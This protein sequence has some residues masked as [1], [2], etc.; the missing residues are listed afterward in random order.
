MNLSSSSQ[1]QENHNNKMIIV[2][3]NIPLQKLPFDEKRNILMRLFC[4][5]MNQTLRTI[6]LSNQLEIDV[7]VK[8]EEGVSLDLCC[9]DRSRLEKA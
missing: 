3:R 2:W 8:K 7:S 4:I 9:S 1:R 5:T 6:A